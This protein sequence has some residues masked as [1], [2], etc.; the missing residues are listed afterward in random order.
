MSFLNPFF[1][2]ALLTVA[3]PLL[4]Y[5]LN[6]RKPKKVRFS[7]LAF[8]DS[9]K[10][11]A[12]KRIRIK[13]WLLLAIR[14]LA[15]LALV[16]AASRPFLPPE[17]GWSSNNQPKAIGILIDNS[18]TMNRVDRNGP[19]SEQAK[20]AVRDIL[21]IAGDDDRILMDVTNGGSLNVP[22][23]SQRAALNRLEDIGTVNAGNYLADRLQSVAERLMEADQPNKILYLITDGQESQFSE[24]EESESVIEEINV[25]VLTVGSGDALNLGYESV[26]IEYGGMS[27]S[28]NVQLRANV[29]NEGNQTAA[30]QFINLYQGGE[31]ITQQAFDL[32][33]GS[34]R[35]FLFD[36]PVGNQ[37]SLRVELFLEGDELSF[38]NRYYAAIELPDEKNILV[39]NQQPETA[40]FQSY[41]L[42]MLEIASD[43]SGRMNI[44]FA[45]INNFQVSELNQYDAVI[46][47]GIRRVPDYLSEPLTDHV[48][49]GAGL[50]FMPAANGDVT[51]YNRLLNFSNAG[52]YSN[53]IGSYG[54]FE[55][56]DRMAEPAEGHPIMDQMFEKPEDEEI[57]LNVPELFYYYEIAMGNQSSGF[58]ILQTRTGNPLLVENRVGSGKMIYSA[59]GSDPGWSNFPVKPFFAPLFYR[60]L[61]YL[62]QGE[63]ATLQVHELGAPFLAELNENSESIQLVKDDEI[64]LPEIQQTFQGARV[65]YHATEWEPGWLT[66]QSNNQTILFSVNQ[67]A[68][69]SILGSL[70]EDQLTESIGTLF[71]NV[72]VVEGGVDN[73][74]LENE[75]ELASFGREI[76]YWFVLIAII[77]LL[78]ELLVSR[79]FKAETFE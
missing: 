26:E 73:A 66:L 15:I 70:N 43:E 11:T 55:P 17:Y 6:V 47:D 57:R 30:N 50:L 59:I 10:S 4:I 61:D 9:L 36:L 5:L 1:L 39:F 40:D 21:S 71:S 3:V 76:W 64:I 33:A 72:Y 27:Q 44:Q 25:Q 65:T 19:Y 51:S 68:M 60:T 35:E 63:D 16:L 8:F 46:L 18:P 53:V 29:L 58:S 54:S 32:N 12:L 75:L 62:V 77:L 22:L 20:N 48:Q 69:E 49:A 41:L 74:Q 23:I 67:N 45:N 34:S 13:R 31:L 52:R 78:L 14:C 7:T 79:Y 24:F 38:D 56:V 37:D 2:F 42:P 28:G